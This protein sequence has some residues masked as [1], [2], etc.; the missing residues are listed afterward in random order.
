M[1]LYSTGS[2]WGSSMAFLARVE[3]CWLMLGVPLGPQ[4]FLD[5]NMLVS[6]TQK[7]RVRGLAQCEPPTRGVSQCSGI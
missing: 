3:H 1:E 4:G 7:S 2:H 5:T 6:A